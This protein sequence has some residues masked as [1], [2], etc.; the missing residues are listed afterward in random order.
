MQYQ[1]QQSIDTFGT[2]SITWAASI[3]SRE[4]PRLLDLFGDRRY[5]HMFVARE[6]LAAIEGDP[7]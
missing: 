7:A 5:R 1:S 2:S 3:T 4:I 6:I